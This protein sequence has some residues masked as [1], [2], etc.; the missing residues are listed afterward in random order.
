MDMREK[1]SEWVEVFLKN[2]DVFNRIITGFE[3]VNGDILVKRTTNDLF[4]FVR[5]ELE[6]VDDVSSRDGPCVLAVLNNKRNLD[7]I[8]KNWDALSKKKELCVYFV[9]PLANDKWLLFPH[10]HNQITEK[11]AL[12]KG[13]ESMF[14]MVPSV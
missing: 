1:L 4:V 5:P 7:V 3:K 14:S 13:L 10:T 11:S 9:N 2:R 12:R 6:R 8:I